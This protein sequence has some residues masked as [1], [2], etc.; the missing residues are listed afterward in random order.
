MNTTETL[1]TINGFKLR[2]QNDLYFMVEPDGGTMVNVSSTK[3]E[4][5][6][7]LNRWKNEIDTNNHFILAVENV[8][9][10][11]LQAIKC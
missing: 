2:K 9:I 11:K 4:V 7:E 8:F 1:C 5:T 6:D 3:Q 10:D